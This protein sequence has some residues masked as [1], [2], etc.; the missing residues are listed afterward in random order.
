MNPEVRETNT[1]STR[2]ST[3]PR[4]PGDE[5][6]FTKETA[7]QAGKL[8]YHKKYNAAVKEVEQ[9]KEEIKELKLKHRNDI[10]RLK[11]DLAAAKLEHQK[12]V[13]SMSTEQQVEALTEVTPLR[14]LICKYNELQAKEE[15]G[16]LTSKEAAQLDE[17]AATLLTFQ[18]KAKQIT[19][20]QD[21][22]ES[23]ESTND[24]IDSILASFS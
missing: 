15:S 24:D 10:A 12:E 20:K 17:Y 9:L 2:R 7:S 14:R 22:S 23:T 1:Q 4:T 11:H 16:D 21:K 5:F 13:M 6:E 19:S 18:P 3:M 8:S